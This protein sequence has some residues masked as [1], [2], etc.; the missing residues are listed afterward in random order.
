VDASFSKV[1]GVMVWGVLRVGIFSISFLVGLLY[2][3]SPGSTADS[4]DRRTD[5]VRENLKLK[6]IDAKTVVIPYVS[7]SISDVHVTRM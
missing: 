2:F 1:E 4:D 7:R 6:G 5:V 3:G